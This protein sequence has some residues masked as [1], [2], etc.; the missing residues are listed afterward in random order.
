[1]NAKDEMWREEEREKEGNIGMKQAR[2]NEKGT[3]KQGERNIS[4]RRKKN[5][6]RGS[7]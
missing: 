5:V 1:M 2:E 3:S 4:G 7:G 6:S